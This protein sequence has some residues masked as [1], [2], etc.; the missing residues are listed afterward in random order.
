MKQT[1]GGDSQS[2]SASERLV[3][4][5]TGW[6][7]VVIAVLL[8][9]SMVLGAGIGA[10]EEDSSLDQF[11]TD[12]PEADAYEDAQER[13]GVEENETSPRSSSGTTTSSRESRFSKR[14]PSSVTSGRTKP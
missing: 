4:A 5:I 7:R 14:S 9:L 3:N 8:V 11:E 1:R 6:R 2:P 10:L 13:F 12:P